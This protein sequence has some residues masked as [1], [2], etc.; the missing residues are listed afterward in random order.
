VD[1][2][3]SESYASHVRFFARVKPNDPAQDT[4]ESSKGLPE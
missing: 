3:E 4:G 1:I 2:E